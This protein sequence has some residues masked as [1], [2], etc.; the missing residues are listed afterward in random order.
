VLGNPYFRF[1]NVDCAKSITL[2]GQEMIKNSIIEAENYVDYLKT[3]KHIKPEIITK[4]E[5]E[6]N[7]Y[8]R[9]AKHIVT[10]DTDSLF[11][12]FENIINKKD[13]NIIEKIDKYC[14]QVQKFLNE[15]I[16]A[17]LVKKHNIDT[18][19]NKLEL[20]NELIIDRSL[21]LSKKHYAIHVIKREGVLINENISMGL[22]TKRS[23]YPSYTK[24]CLEKLIDMI[25]ND[26]SF[27]I[28][29][30]F[31]FI[32]DVKKEFAIKITK[33]DKTVARPV[34]FNKKIEEYKSITQ[35]VRGMGYWNDIE[36]VAFQTGSKG[37]LFQI[38]G[39]DLEKA[40]ENVKNNYINKYL[41]NGKSID[42]IVLPEDE[43]RLPNYYIV[44]NNE[45]LDFAW[46]KRYELLLDPI[47][48]NNE[49]T[50]PLT[51]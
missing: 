2:T 46:K 48:K 5:I 39:I 34:S 16:I 9:P 24:E 27:S 23:D 45:M 4:K 36:Y 43:D 20:K 42:V 30:I 50:D 18:T 1:F 31:D 10:S 33:G 37:Y 26:K 19:M 12:T 6:S 40:P 28:I 32:E 25:L 21:F 3:G 15:E 51:F 44:K 38:H 41:N 29:K 47:I 49:K 13:E 17:H 22:D 8:E 11:I 14:V 35:A 7:Q